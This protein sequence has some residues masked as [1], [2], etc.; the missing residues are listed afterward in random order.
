MQKKF[1]APRLV[2]VL[3]QT[4]PSGDKRRSGTHRVGLTALLCAI[5]GC[6]SGTPGARDAADELVSPQASVPAAETS[7]TR[8]EEALADATPPAGRSRASRS[9]D[10]SDLPWLSPSHVGAA[11]RAHHDDFQ[12]CQALGDLES[13]R[14]DGAVTVGW[15]VL[16]DGSVNDVTVGPS[17]FQSARINACVLHVA[18]QVTFPRS[19]S[20]ANISWTLEFRGAASHAPIATAR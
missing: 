10:R 5:L 7:S 9:S 14:E 20:P 17:T 19:G 11:V 12:A 6:A 16:P 3:A 4:E 8:R 15:L 13:R 18:R 1:R 2:A